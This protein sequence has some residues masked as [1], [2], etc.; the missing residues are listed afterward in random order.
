MYNLMLRIPQL[1]AYNVLYNTL[2][3]CIQYLYTFNF[4]FDKI[5]NEY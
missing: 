2:H 1:Y 3:D 4:N 5:I